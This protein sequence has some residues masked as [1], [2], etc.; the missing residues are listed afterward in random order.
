[1]FPLAN[2]LHL[3]PDKLARLRRWRFSFALVFPSSFNCFLFWHSK[4]VS[5]EKI[6]LA[7]CRLNWDVGVIL[8]CDKLEVCRPSQAGCLTS[9]S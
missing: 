1:M 5:L 6:W 7:V 4:V 9:K 3:F 2:M 8:L